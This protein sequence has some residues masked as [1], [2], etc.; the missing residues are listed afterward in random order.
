MAL[1][2]INDLHSLV[3]AAQDDSAAVRMGALLALRRL[4]RA[5][6]ATFLND[7][8]PLIVTEAARAIND[9]P[10]SGAIPE[11]AAFGDKIA[12]QN[13]EPVPPELSRR[14]VNANYRYGTRESAL[15]LA[16]LASN[17]SIPAA[18]RAEAVSNLSNWLNP[19]GRDNVTGLW[20]PV[21]GPRDER[22]AVEAI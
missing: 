4:E 11:L 1:V 5:E 21:V 15:R 3:A 6:I 19:S 8:S 7:K 9:L 22:H 2:G 12:S 10:I 20:R 17:T 14:V 18:T 13:S 16:K